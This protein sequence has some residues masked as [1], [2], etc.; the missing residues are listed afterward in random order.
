MYNELLKLEQ[1]FPNIKL[2]RKRFSTI[3]GGASLL[4]MLLASMEDLLTMY[5][6]WKWNFVLNLSESDFP[7][8]TLDKLV[9]F[10]TAN[11]D[12]NFVKS[13]GREVQRF[14]QKQGLDKTF[15]ECDTHMFRIGDRELPEGIQID[16][17]SD[18]ICLSRNFIEFVINNA[19]NNELIRGLLVVFRQT[20]LPAESF[21][22]TV[23]R[24]SQF[25]DTYIDNNLHVTNWKRKL[26]CKCQ[27]KHVVDWCGC[28]P[29]DFKLDDWSRLQ[30]TE[31]KQ[32]FFA[33]KFEPIVNQAIIMQVEE[34][35]YGPYPSDYGNLNSYWENVYHNHD[36]INNDMAVLLTVA[37]VCIKDNLKKIGLEQTSVKILEITNHMQGDVYKGFIV[38][39]RIGERYSVETL[40]KPNQTAQVSKHAK[41]AKRITMF[42]AST[43][44]DQKEQIS[45][46]FPRTI[47]VH[48]EPVLIF[49]ILSIA[50]LVAAG[51]TITT[52]PN[53]T[54]HNLQIVWLNPSDQVVETTDLTVEE[55]QSS[56]IHFSK[57]NFQ[58][59]KKNSHLDIGTW[60]V[61]MM[62]KN[63]L[64][65]LSRFPVIPIITPA[66]ELTSSGQK[67]RKN[68]KDNI[69]PWKDNIKNI[70]EY[71][72][73][74]LR[75]NLIIKFYEIKDSC[76]AGRIS[77]LNIQKSINDNVNNI[78]DE[79]ED[80]VNVNIDSGDDDIYDDIMME[81]LMKLSDCELTLWSTRAPDPKSELVYEEMIQR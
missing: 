40:I 10:L 14:I 58:T 19:Q 67:Y 73:K 80:N 22:H 6:N 60:T 2:A 20:L 43:D 5:S 68:T 37:M 72:D 34:W 29:N 38:H 24:N 61:K 49:R 47:G 36:K 39:Y 63:I 75:D 77:K 54:S 16:G 41:L 23:L 69:I 46:N 3:W 52:E 64:I 56:S 9:R 32:I 21:F 74:L 26:G 8:K 4:Q 45:R 48:S 18:W 81:K 7:V 59:G 78:G 15:V 44:F 13:H 65:G 28:S 71:E 11:R 62:H 57:P 51:V 30:A 50:Q 25:C 17:G 53:V 1:K 27:Y 35:M 66:T 70:E 42:E 76:I 12:K 33:R 79:N 31:L 55:T